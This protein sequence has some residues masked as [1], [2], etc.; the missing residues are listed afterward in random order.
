[1]LCS[2]EWQE[3]LWIGSNVGRTGR[4]LLWALPKCAW[5]DWE[6]LGSFHSRQLGRES[7]RQPSEC[8]ANC[9]RSTVTFC[10]RRSTRNVR[11][12]YGWALI[13]DLS[14]KADRYSCCSQIKP[15]GKVNKNKK[16]RCK[17][18]H[19]KAQSRPSRLTISNADRCQAVLYESARKRASSVRGAAVA[20]LSS[21]VLPSSARQ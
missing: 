11:R 5:T 3:E 15:T 2:V 10:R 16:E 6:R 20:L 7:N 13:E 17:Y 1:M 12:R 21:H 4:G 19:C 9:N 18:S 14:T 8:E